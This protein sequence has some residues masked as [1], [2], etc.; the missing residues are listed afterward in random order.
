MEN[1]GETLLP[2]KE[3]ASPGQDQGGAWPSG[4]LGKEEKVVG[5][6]VS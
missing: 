5:Q 3:G 4:T 1:E 6:R 2:Q